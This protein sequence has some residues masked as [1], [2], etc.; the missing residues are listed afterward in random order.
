[1]CL[2][3]SQ[4]RQ[5]VGAVQTAEVSWTLEQTRQRSFWRHLDAV[6]PRSRQF[7]H[8]R[9]RCR[10]S[11]LR[12]ISFAIRTSDGGAQLN[13]KMTASVVTWTSPMRFLSL[14][15]LI[16]PY[17]ES[18]A[19]I[20]SSASSFG[21]PKMIF[22][23]SVSQFV[24]LH[25]TS[26]SPNF[27]CCNN[28]SLVDWSSA[29]T[30]RS[31]PVPTRVDVRGKLIDKADKIDLRSLKDNCLKHFLRDW[32]EIITG[33]R[34]DWFETRKE[35]EL[36]EEETDWR[37]S[38][39]RELGWEITELFFETSIGSIV[40]GKRRSRR[41]KNYKGQREERRV[42]EVRENKEKK[43][44]RKILARKIRTKLIT[45]KIRDEV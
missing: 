29:W 2:L 9:G 23:H 39:L 25:F 15:A 11:W 17:R 45:S 21:T 18:S 12:K 24:R 20:S 27:S 35:S 30:K 22:L 8:N 3:L 42:E 16:T 41:V 28:K 10:G 34:I 44:E 43:R 32:K 14:R 4:L 33:K 7:L 40:A 13:P 36:L 38:L 19:T 5:R 31:P 37:L 1:M 26:I 6:C